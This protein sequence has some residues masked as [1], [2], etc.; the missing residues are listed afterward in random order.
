VSGQ[1]DNQIGVRHGRSGFVRRFLT[2]SPRTELARFDA[3]ADMFGGGVQKR[4]NLRRGGSQTIQNRSPGRAAPQATIS[5]PP[6]PSPYRRGSFAS[7]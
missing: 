6:P 1:S 5:D 3:D 7:R 2:V 4:R